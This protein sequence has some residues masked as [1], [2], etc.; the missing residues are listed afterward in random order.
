MSER[1]KD[2]WR[3]ALGPEEPLSSCHPISLRGRSIKDAWQ[4]PLLCGLPGHLKPPGLG[5]CCHL[6]GMVSSSP[7][8]SLLLILPAQSTHHFLQALHKLSLILNPAAYEPCALGQA[9]Q[10]PRFSV[11]SSAE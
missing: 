1:N 11:S 5:Q 3:T 6:P 9:T 2:T 10:P 4:S 7:P 8:V